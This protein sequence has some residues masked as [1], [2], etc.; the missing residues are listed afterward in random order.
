MDMGAFT[1]AN[2]AI[3]ANAAAAFADSPKAPLSLVA[4]GLAV[5]GLLMVAAAIAALWRHRPLR[6]AGWAMTGAL[7]VALGALSGS[8]AVGIQGYRVLTAE[9]VAALIEV[10]PIAPQR[11]SATFRLADGTTSTHELAGDELYVDAHILKWKPVGHLFGLQT[12]WSL[13][14]VA[15]RYRSI[16]DERTAPRT[17]HALA[18][19]RSV[20]LF[21]LRRR[22]AAL[23]PFY[24]AEYGSATYLPVT[25]PAELELRVTTSGL[26][27][28]ALRP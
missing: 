14:R 20:D 21:Q 2:A 18:P 3:A 16:E 8:L 27:L 17:V 9:E 19:G 1:A 10:R 11:F 26:L 24:D 12:L 5:I 6:F 13:D 22:H 4:T 28:R 25:G 23:S 7:F 15:G